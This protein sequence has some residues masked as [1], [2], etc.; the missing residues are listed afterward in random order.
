[1]NTLDEIDTYITRTYTRIRG[2]DQA[3]QLDMDY[4]T[5]I[6]RRSRLVRAGLLTTV[7]RRYNRLWTQDE[8]DQILVMA[9]SGASIAEIA[10]VLRRDVQATYD[11]VE[12]VMGGLMKLRRGRVWSAR[13]V[14]KLFTVPWNTIDDWIRLGWLQAT[15]NQTGEQTW[16]P[17]YLVTTSAIIE[18]LNVREA[19]ADWSPNMI[20][21]PAWRDEGQR[22]RDAT[23]GDWLS[24][25]EL[26]GRYHYGLT[27]IQGWLQR[28]ELPFIKRGRRVF[29]WSG[30][31]DGFIPPAERDRRAA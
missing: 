12:R 6:K 1:M 16:K 3:K 7:K 27:T 14:Q 18:F 10:Q 23:G 20:T 21:Q 9:S 31:L 19:W 8:R 13:Q 2:K 4:N 29:V 30:D 5:V 22:I 15:R 24:I 26:M 11:Y 17:R 25:R 28:G